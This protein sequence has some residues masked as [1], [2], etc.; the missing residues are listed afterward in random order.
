M[1]TV[2]YNIDDFR[3][4]SN[5]RFNII[6]SISAII[7]PLK[8]KWLNTLFI[9]GINKDFATLLKKTKVIA[10]AA[11]KIDRETAT[12]TYPKV[13]TTLFKFRKVVAN[14][15][16]K[17][18]YNNSTTK[19][20]SESI[21]DNFYSIELSTRIIAF[22]DTPTN[23]REDEKGLVEFASRVSLRSLQGH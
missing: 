19:R 3:M 4:K 10:E 16:K 22:D 9:R 2:N 11:N 12:E 23:K 6:A 20:L 13:K 17:N 8:I 5:F 7:L 14:L 21:L 18:Y 1:S 15:E